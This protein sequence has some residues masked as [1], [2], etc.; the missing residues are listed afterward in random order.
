MPDRTCPKCGFAQPDT[1]AECAQCGVVFEKYHEQRDAL[2]KKTSA[3][4]GPHKPVVRKRVRPLTYIMLLVFFGLA[5]YQLRNLDVLR[6]PPSTWS[7][8]EDV[9]RGGTIDVKKRGRVEAIPIADEEEWD[10]ELQYGLKV[11]ADATLLSEVEVTDPDAQQQHIARY[12]TMLPFDEILQFYTDEFGWTR[13]MEQQITP[14]QGVEVGADLQSVVGMRARWYV[15]SADEEGNSLKVDVVIQSP[16]FDPDG[17][18][19]PDS[20]L[21]ALSHLR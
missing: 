7:G 19:H 12:E 18:Y 21:I 15:L 16:F 5:W 3:R 6:N 8:D 4:K 13:A 9:S 14:P 20:T 17:T 2:L 11:V 1:N 10:G